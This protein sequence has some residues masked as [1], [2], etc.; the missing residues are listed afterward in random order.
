MSKSL[1][2]V[3]N[4]I[5]IIEGGRDLKKQPAYGADVLRLWV[6]SVDY[7]GDV[8]I[9]DNIVKQ[10]FESYRK[11]RNTARYLLGNLADFQ[12]KEHS[13][14]YD[15]LPSLDKWMLG[16][17][18]AV[19]KEVNNAYGE[20]QF[21]RAT[22]ELIKFSTVDLSNFYL[23]IA[24]DRLYISDVDDFRRRSCQTVLH[25]CLEGFAKVCLEAFEFRLI[26]LC[27]K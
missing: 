13:V 16:R 4:P 10:T 12:P 6:A 15:K 5:E 8:C 1:G 20:Y 26:I 18:A 19:L 9:G 27:A 24:K 23:D 11:L 25:M 2:N 14:L 3:V 17:L 7:S 21:Y 22:Q